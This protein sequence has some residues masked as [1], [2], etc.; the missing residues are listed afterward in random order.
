MKN[1]LVSTNL[2]PVDSSTSRQYLRSTVAMGSF[3]VVPAARTLRNDGV[4]SMR[5][6]IQRPTTSSTPDRRNGMRQPKDSNASSGKTARAAIVTMLPSARP[7]SA[8]ICGTAP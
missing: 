4:S 6:R 8:P 3:W 5:L 7:A 1:V 2:A